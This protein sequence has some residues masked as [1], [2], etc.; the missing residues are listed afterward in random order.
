MLYAD[1]ERRYIIAPKGVEAGAKL[2]SAVDAPIKAGNCLPLRNIP[3]GTTVHC[4]EMKPGRGAQLARS[5]G[6]GVQLMAK[7]GAYATA[8]ALRRDAQ[9]T[10]GMQSDYWRSGQYPA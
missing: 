4:L 7:E 10:R 5:A 1:G 6:A 9:S 8:L 3:V 2:I